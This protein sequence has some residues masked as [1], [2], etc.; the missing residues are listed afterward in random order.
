MKKFLMLATSLFLV[1]GVSVAQA[2]DSD[3]MG[4]YFD[5]Y[6]QDSCIDSDNLA[7]YTMLDLH[8]LLMNPTYPELLGFEMG[9]TIDGPAMLLAANIANPQ[10]IDV[11]SIG[12]H[13]IGFAEPMVLE[14]VNHLATFE[15]M[16]T[17]SD[18][19]AVCFILHG[20][21]PSS[22]NPLYPTANIR[23]LKIPT[24]EGMR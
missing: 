20:S 10:F 5:L 14:P 9:M 16:Y 12:N 21:E 18:S 6:G 8:L 24:C 19:E 23:G 3:N 13:V 22:V 1:F 15:I 17:S 2:Q 4:L 7:P 11:G